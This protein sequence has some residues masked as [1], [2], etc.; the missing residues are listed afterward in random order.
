MSASPN[1]TPHGQMLGTSSHRISRPAPTSIARTSTPPNSMTTASHGSPLRNQRL[2]STRSSQS[3]PCIQPFQSPRGAVDPS[4]PASGTAS[5]GRP[6]E[7]VYDTII[8]RH[9]PLWGRVRVFIKGEDWSR[10]PNGK[11]GD[12]RIWSRRLN[13]RMEMGSPR[14]GMICMRSCRRAP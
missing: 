4:A 1:I 10:I 14:L 8:G 2:T 13:G 9:S 5:H 11:L 12:W 6:E 7:I 3:I